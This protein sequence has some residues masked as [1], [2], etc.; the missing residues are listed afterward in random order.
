MSLFSSKLDDQTSITLVEDSLVLD[1][2]F[3]VGIPWK[4]NVEDSL[5]LDGHFSVGIPWKENPDNL[6]NNK[7]T[8][9]RCLLGLKKP[10]EPNPELHVAYTVEMQNWINSGFINSCNSNSSLCHSILHHPV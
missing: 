1:G 7:D 5:V 10:F 8:A 2:H 6:P 4:E 9:I 3:S